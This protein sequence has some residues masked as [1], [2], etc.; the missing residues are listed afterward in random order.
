MNELTGTQQ[1][2]EMAIKTE[3]VVAL[4]DFI[5]CGV[6]KPNAAGLAN[7]QSDRLV[8]FARIVMR[9][10]EATKQKAE[11]TA[12]Q[13]AVYAA[14]LVC[15]DEAGSLLMDDSDMAQ[16]IYVNRPALAALTF[17]ASVLSLPKVAE[18]ILS[19]QR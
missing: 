12:G 13:M 2:N 6:L 1:F 17:V 18:L 11:D 9:Q 14:M 19:E 8:Y 3:K 16:F 7:A 10:A 5:P 15:G 4:G